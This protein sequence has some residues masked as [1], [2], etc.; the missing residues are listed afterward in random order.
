LWS[1]NA[2]AVPAVQCKEEGPLF[3]LVKG[4]SKPVNRHQVIREILDGLTWGW[5]TFP[6]QESGDGCMGT[7]TISAS[8]IPGATARR[9]H[10]RRPGREVKRYIGLTS[11]K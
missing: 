8:L 5:W 7:N 3:T 9:D 11:W 10:R 2:M 1:W 4:S 6:K